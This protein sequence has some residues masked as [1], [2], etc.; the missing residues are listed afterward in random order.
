[1]CLKSGNVSVLRGGS[2]AIN[3]NK[4]I[5]KC[6]IEGLL[7]AGM[8]KNSIQLIKNQD[9]ALVA[10]MIKRDK[11]IDLIIPRGGKN[12]IQVIIVLL[13]LLLVNI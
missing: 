1:M 5:E 7:A 10:E 11:E 3:S 9:R 4:A 8:P 12:L 13:L 6:M 2:E